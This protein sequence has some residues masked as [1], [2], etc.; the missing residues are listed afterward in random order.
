MA[1]HCVWFLIAFFYPP[2][3]SSYCTVTTQLPAL[4]IISFHTPTIYAPCDSYLWD[5]AIHMTPTARHGVNAYR[6]C[7]QTNISQRDF[8]KWPSGW[9]STIRSTRHTWWHL[10]IQRIAESYP[11][12]TRILTKEQCRSKGNKLAVPLMTAQIICTGSQVT[13]NQLVMIK[14]HSFSCPAIAGNLPFGHQISWT[15]MMTV[16][17]TYHICLMYIGKDL[18]ILLH[19]D[20]CMDAVSVSYCKLHVLL[21]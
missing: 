11:I 8:S 5:H 17:C 3:H 18:P 9:K 12:R 2:Y 10:W 4:P 21:E 20:G 13:T 15:W 6:C 16:I 19:L 14:A 7:S 1:T